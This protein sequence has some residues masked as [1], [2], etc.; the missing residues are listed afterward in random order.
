MSSTVHELKLK[1][2]R[3]KVVKYEHFLNERLKP[4]LKAVLDERDGI[5]TETAEF[6]ALRN[7]ISAIQAAELDPAEALKTKVDLGCN[8]YCRANVDDPSKIFVE[9][10][11]GFYLEFSLDE[12]EKFVDKKISALESK[13]KELTDQSSKI[14]ANIRLVLEGLRELQNI[15]NEK[16]KKTNYEP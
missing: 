13:S 3:E 14:K 4:D 7:S 8:F 16:D 6:L 5:Y 9:I 11:L 1:Q 12:A 2:V 10:G 15:S